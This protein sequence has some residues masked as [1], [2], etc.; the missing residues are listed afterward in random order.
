DIALVIVAIA[1]RRISSLRGCALSRFAPDRSRFCCGLANHLS[2]T[3]LKTDSV[4]PCFAANL[5][6]RLLAQAGPAVVRLNPW[7]DRNCPKVKGPA[8]RSAGPLLLYRF[9]RL[10]AVAHEPQQEQ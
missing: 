10:A 1:H 6:P 3:A 8:D 2:S 5:T 9:C 4:K 7:Q